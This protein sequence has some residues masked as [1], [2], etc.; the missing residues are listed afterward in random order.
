MPDPR[1][2]VVYS[3][4]GCHLCEVVKESLSQALAPRRL[5]L[6]GNR[7]RRRRRT[8]PPVQ[9]RSPRGLH[10]WAQSLQVPHGRAGISPQARQLNFLRRNRHASATISPGMLRTQLYAD[11]HNL[12]LHD[13]VLDSCRRQS[14]ENR[15]G[16]CFLRSPHHLRRIRRDGRIPRPRPDCR[17]RQ[18]RAKSSPSSWPTPGNSAPPITPPRSPEPSPR[19][20]IPPIASAKSAISWRTPDAVLLI[21]DGANLEGIRPRRIAQ[22]APRLHHAPAGSGRR[23]FCQPAQTG[24]WQPIPSPT[25]RPN[26]LLPRFPIRAGPPACPRASCSRTTTWS[27]MSTS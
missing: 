26:K 8:P 10:R 11:P 13:L 6:A 24:D 1:N 4:K 14:A 20:S 16:G 23:T 19:C 21:T 3:R 17:R 5:H 9:R 7:R 25:S 15:A 27:R 18:A 12:F 2:V 22:S